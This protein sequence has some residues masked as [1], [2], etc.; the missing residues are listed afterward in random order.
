MMGERLT[1]RKLI[2]MEAAVSAMLAGM[3]G[4]GDW[5]DDLPKRDLEAAEDWINEQ[6][7]KRERPNP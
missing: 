7:A 1:L 3:E 6:I 4:E 2:A 5:P